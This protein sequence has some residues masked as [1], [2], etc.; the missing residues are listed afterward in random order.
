MAFEAG[1]DLVLQAPMVASRNALQSLMKRRGDALDRD[2]WHRPNSKMS[3]ILVRPEEIGSGYAGLSTYG[4]QSRCLQ[5]RMAGHSEW[6]HASIWIRPSHGDMVSFT[7]NLEP[8]GLKGVDYAMLVGVA[9]E[10]AHQ[11]ATPASATKT[12]MT[13]ESSAIDSSPNV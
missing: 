13:V 10:A 11:I 3:G 6:G 7:N 9:R 5:S 1:D 2:G 4:S 12:S 8:E